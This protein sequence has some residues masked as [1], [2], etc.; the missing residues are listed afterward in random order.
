MKLLFFKGSC[1]Y[2][3]MKICTMLIM[4]HTYRN[5]EQIKIHSWD[6]F[7]V[8]HQGFFVWCA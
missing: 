3:T 2:L 4:S 7:R 5:L 1:L 8:I 6:F